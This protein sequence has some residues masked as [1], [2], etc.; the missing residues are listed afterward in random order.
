MA[1]P[2][3]AGTVGPQ[4]DAAKDIPLFCL[5][6]AREWNR[7]WT[8][9]HE[10]WAKKQLRGLRAWCWV[11]EYQERGA[12]HV[13]FVLWTMKTL[14]QLIDQNNNGNPKDIIVSCAAT[15]S[16]A[17][18]Q[19]LIN[20]HQIHQYRVDYCARERETGGCYCRFDFPREQSETTFARGG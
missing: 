11:T 13:H 7:I 3:I 8:F 16:D 19:T 4:R 15:S 10:K 20:T 2:N 17:N 9:I 12:P 6:Y 1:S 14:Q 18:L 5:A